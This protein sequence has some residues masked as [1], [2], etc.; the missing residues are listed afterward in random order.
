MA[1]VLTM[2]TLYAQVVVL[3]SAIA[4]VIIPALIHHR[5]GES[6][7]VKSRK[8]PLERVLLT[9]ASI[10]FFLALLWVATPALRFAD[11]S[12]RP[13]PFIAGTSCLALGLWFLY[14]SHAD[15]G[16]NWSITLEVREN[17]QLVTQ[18]IYRHVR[19]PMYLSL[20]LHA[21]GLV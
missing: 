15:L 10:G 5:G 11:Y 13:V 1:S 7:V 21:S 18:G 6:K 9:S 3:V 20:L 12:L 16:T 19:H 14:R 4:V 8:G 17:H 2:N